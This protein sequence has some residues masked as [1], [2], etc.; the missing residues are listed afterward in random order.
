MLRLLRPLLDKS[1][2]QLNSSMSVDPQ[3]QFLNTS[4]RVVPSSSTACFSGDREDG[5]S[6]VSFKNCFDVSKTRPQVL[7]VFGKD[8][9]ANSINP[10]NSSVL[11]FCDCIRINLKMFDCELR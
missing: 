5:K 3:G 10:E 7:H 9:S 2:R 8:D 1:L 4:T 11:S 6:S